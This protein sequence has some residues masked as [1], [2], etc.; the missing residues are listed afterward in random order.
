MIGLIDSLVMLLSTD[1]FKEYWP[2]I[3]I[4]L[5]EKASMA[6]QEGCREIVGQIM[7]GANE[8]WLAN[9]SDE[10]KWETRLRLKSLMKKLNLESVTNPAFEEWTQVDNEELDAGALYETLTSDLLSDEIAED[11]DSDIKSSVA[12]IYHQTEYGQVNFEDLCL[13]SRTDWDNYIRGLTPE[14]PSALVDTLL[15]FLKARRFKTLWC[16]LRKTLTLAQREE[17]I[18]RYRKMA[19]AFAG[20]D[21]IPAYLD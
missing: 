19:K 3:G 6:M 14:L 1:W 11:L 10:R 8:Y 4:D 5:D 7:S 18:A 15:A 20:W 2:I 17:L 9:L 16:S 21:V 13:R 12:C